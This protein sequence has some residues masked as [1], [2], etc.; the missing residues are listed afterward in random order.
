MEILRIL[1][2][3]RIKIGTVVYEAADIAAGPL[4]VSGWRGRCPVVIRRGKV[5]SLLLERLVTVRR[6]KNE[7]RKQC[8]S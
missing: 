1:T 6:A 7:G 8:Q 5:V 3:S 2:P 4:V